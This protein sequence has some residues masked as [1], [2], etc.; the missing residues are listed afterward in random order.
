[1]MVSKSWVKIHKGKLYI[2]DPGIITVLVLIS[3]LVH[4]A[5]QCLPSFLFYQEFRLSTTDLF[6]WECH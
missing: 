5:A 4:F 1:M 6:Q 2:F 3:A